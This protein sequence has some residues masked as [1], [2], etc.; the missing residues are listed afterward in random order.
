MTQLLHR[1][2][3]RFIESCHDV[4]NCFLPN[5]P[6]PRGSAKFA[7]VQRKSPSCSYWRQACAR[8]PCPPINTPLTSPPGTWYDPRT[9]R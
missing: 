2:M 8:V 9:Y 5:L 6:V 3:S 1:H 4:F 7:K